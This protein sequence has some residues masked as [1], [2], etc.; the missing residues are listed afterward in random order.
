[1]LRSDYDHFDKYTCSRYSYSVVF[2][3]VENEKRVA[4]IP[5]AFSSALIFI[6]L[7]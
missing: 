2:S 6:V 3:V 5:K 4:E 1:M 7:D